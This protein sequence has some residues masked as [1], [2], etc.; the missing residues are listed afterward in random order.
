MR[1][2]DQKLAA[3][4]KECGCIYSMYGI[5]IIPTIFEVAHSFVA[6]GIFFRRVFATSSKYQVVY[7]YLVPGY[8]YFDKYLIHT[9]YIHSSTIDSIR[10]PF[11][12]YCY[13]YNRAALNIIKG[14]VKVLPTELYG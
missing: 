13:Y 10:V 3:D 12:H 9:R 4:F 11:Y 5:L 7:A 1:K 6:S 8:T 2:T 14:G